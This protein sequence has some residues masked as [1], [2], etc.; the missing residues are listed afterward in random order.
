M[1]ELK[2]EKGCPRIFVN[3]DTLEEAQSVA[4]L[5][6]HFIV[7]TGNANNSAIIS[8]KDGVIADVGIFMRRVRGLYELALRDK[9]KLIKENRY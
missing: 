9:D 2:F 8:F 4:G 7:L 3:E 1:I 5:L 6:N